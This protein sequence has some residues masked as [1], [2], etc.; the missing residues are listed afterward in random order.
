[1]SPAVA[2]AWPSAPRTS[3]EV[4]GGVRR[5]RG[6]FTPRVVLDQ[7]PEVEPVHLQQLA[8][9]AEQ[10]RLARKGRR[11]GWWQPYSSMLSEAYTTYIG[12]EAEAAA[13]LTYQPLIVPG[14]LQTAEYAEAIMLA[15]SAEIDA[16]EAEQ[17]VS[18]RVERQRILTGD[19]PLRLWAVMDEAAL[20]RPV[21]GPDVMRAQLDHLAEMAQSARVTLQVPP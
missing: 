9:S 4:A 20:R 21:G 17:R 2:L 13:V 3:S 6:S 10:L 16:A 11:R 18:V 15:S 7:A 19:D 1:M 12:L 8:L 14:L 5:V